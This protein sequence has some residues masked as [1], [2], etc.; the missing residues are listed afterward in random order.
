MTIGGPSTT[1]EDA[2][3]M[4]LDFCNVSKWNE[5]VK[6][7]PMID[8]AIMYQNGKTEVVL[9]KILLNKTTKTNTSSMVIPNIDVVSVASK[10]NAF[11]TGKN[12]SP[13]GI[14]SQLESSLTSLG[15]NKDSIDIYYLHAPDS[16]HE[17]EPTLQEIQQLYKEKKLHT[18]GLSNFT[19]WE[20]VYIYN[21]MKSR[22]YILPTVYQGMY[23][24]ITRQVETE[25][26]PALRK[27]DMKF[28]AYNPLA[29]GML[30]GKYISPPVS[31]T[32]DKDKELAKLNSTKGDR[33]AGNSMWAK[34]YRE[35]FQQKEQFDALEIVRKQLKLMANNN[36]KSDDTTTATATTTI[37]MAEA[38]LRWIRHHSQLEE[39]D[40]IIMGSS[41]ISHYHSNMKS[42]S[43][44]PLPADLVKAFDDAYQLCEDVCPAYSRGYSGSA[45]TSTKSAASDVVSVPK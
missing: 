26:F 37:S 32:D 30:S 33:F 23:N 28:Y 14:R 8:S 16:N 22:N 18:F 27:L 15:T 29:G 38:S 40:G 34:T 36:D 24:A 4:V 1:Y 19:A 35:R 3:T 13:S 7:D 25:L 11:T 39:E 12:L 45:L 6:D 31:N 42:L 20:T 44:G 17:I 21:Y 9:G 43:G 5:L 10:A 41:K 2:T